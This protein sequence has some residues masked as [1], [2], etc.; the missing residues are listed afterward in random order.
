MPWDEAMGSPSQTPCSIKTPL[1]L[2]LSARTSCRPEKHRAYA[3]QWLGLAL[4]VL[5]GAGAGEEVF[6]MNSMAQMEGAC[7]FWLQ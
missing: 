4:V 3:V 5:V 1:P 6:P 2:S 7:L